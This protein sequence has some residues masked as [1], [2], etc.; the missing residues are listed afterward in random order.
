ME[1]STPLPEVDEAI[2]NI[3]WEWSRIRSKISGAPS[4]SQPSMMSTAFVETSKLAILISEIMS[5]VYG[6]RSGS[7]GLSKTKAVSELR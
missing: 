5:T 3:P 4:G 7:N 6:L 1:Y 2:D